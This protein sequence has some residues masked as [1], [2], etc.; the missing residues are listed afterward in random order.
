MTMEM[1]V[2]EIIFGGKLAFQNFNLQLQS[3]KLCNNKYMVASTQ[4][5]NT[6]IFTFMAVLVFKL[7]S[8]K[9]L[10]INRKDKRNCEKVGHFL[11]K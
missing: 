8:R 1:T 5:T 9:V 10:F 3:C 4:V 11:R 2:A 6:E 7:L